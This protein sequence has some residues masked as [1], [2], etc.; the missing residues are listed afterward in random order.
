MRAAV[1]CTR[2]AAFAVIGAGRAA[3]VLRAEPFPLLIMV[4]F[5]AWPPAAGG[6]PTGSGVA[7]VLTGRWSSG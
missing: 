7:M 6:D 2:A 4:T 5:L 3:E 1:D